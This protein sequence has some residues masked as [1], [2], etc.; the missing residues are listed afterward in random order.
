MDGVYTHWQFQEPATKFPVFDFQA[1]LVKKSPTHST[2][3]RKKIID[4]EK[5]LLLASTSSIL[6]FV[7]VDFFIVFDRLSYSNM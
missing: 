3:C 4:H 1:K 7:T 2:K 5:T 6:F